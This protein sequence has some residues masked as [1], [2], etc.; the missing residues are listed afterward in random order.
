MR[1]AKLLA[2]IC[3]VALIAVVLFSLTQNKVFAASRNNK[4]DV[5]KPA[6]NINQSKLWQQVSEENL[7]T[8]GRRSIVPEK[9]LIYRLNNRE[10]TN[11]FAGAPLEFSAAARKK[12]VVLEIPT[13]DGKLA[14][15]RIEESPMLSP[16]IAAQFPTW[17]TFQ[18]QG[19]EDPTAVARFDTNANGFHGYV[20]GIDGTYLINPYS[21]KD[22]KHYIVYYKSDLS[23]ERDSFTCSVKGKTSAADGFTNLTDVPQVSFTNGI[24]LRNFRLAVSA[25]KQYTNFFNANQITAFAAIQTTVNRLITIYRR[26]L[27]TTFTLVS[28][29]NIVFTDASDGGFTNNSKTDT[30]RNQV[31]LDEIIGNN[32]YDIGHILSVTPNPDGL[33][34]SPSL[35]NDR[36]KAQ[37]FTGAPKP[38]GDGFDLDYVAHE[39]G[40]QFGMSHTFNNNAD[41]SCD[42]REEN[43]AFEPASGVT[44]MGYG[45]ICSPRN[46]AA[47]S[48]EFFH[49]RSFVQTLGYLPTIKECGTTTA[50]GNVA[51][52]N[53]S[54]GQNYTIPKLTPFVLT[55][56]AQDTDPNLTY[57]WE[58]YDLGT[59]TNSK[60]GAPVDTDEDG[61]PRPIFR[62]Y[63]PTTEPF[64]V[65]PSLY[66]IL[67]N[68][69]TPPLTYTGKLPLRREA[70]TGG[71]YACAPGETC[72][73]GERLPSIARVMNFRVTVRDNNANGGGVADANAQ[74][75]VDGTSG[76]F[77]VTAQNTAAPW[78]I[79]TQQ[80]ITWDVANTNNAAVNAQ[81][82][83]ITLSTDG[84]DTFSV[85]IA[86]STPNDGTEIITVPNNPTTQA[87]LKIEAIGNVFFDINNANYVISSNNIINVTVGGRVLN[88]AGEPILDARLKLTDASG[89]TRTAVTDASGVYR[90]TGVAAGETYT[91]SVEAK[92]TTFSEP[93]RTLQITE[94][95]NNIDFTAAPE[96]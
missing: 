61:N 31:V 93:S 66:Y 24:E 18:G 1:Y 82:V 38:N 14:H 53:V 83:K 17:K 46:L 48:I 56:G 23:A 41:G 78:Q 44:I 60:N 37:G 25:S 81:N 13:P 88:A 22:R 45:G 84:G 11:R 7:K 20:I 73:T 27:A 76:P 52:A 49:A 33:A 69:N 95:T 91:F 58:E 62:S 63:N 39:I 90:F 75:T 4:F 57:A 16:E 77:R 64:R 67:N 35:C 47:S 96:E 15:F 89:N 28:G 5:R 26:E 32:K 59:P 79:G 30:D 50:T 68:D 54:A 74:I 71:G 86:E 8:R 36:A 94:D 80:T 85:V 55:A 92:R 21:E 34:S 19:I 51:P 65:F 12:Q 40:H 2:K 6:K 9:Y 10:L 87:R 43:S 70:K 3:F 72:V 29:T 42:T